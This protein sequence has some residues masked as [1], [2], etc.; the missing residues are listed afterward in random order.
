[1]AVLVLVWLYL[2]NMEIIQERQS[3]EWLGSQVTI[4]KTK[5]EVR[6]IMGS[7]H[8][9]DPE[10]VWMWVMD[11]G[12]Y[13]RDSFDWRTIETSGHGAFFVVFNHDRVFTMLYSNASSTPL[14]A[15]KGHGMD[16]SEAKELL[17]PDP[18]AAR[19]GKNMAR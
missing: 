17:G 7:P 16:E 10:H 15:L 2:A 5:E 4:G 14:A 9:T 13:L 1:M 19:L 3:I 12:L 11:D 18:K 6:R 8:N